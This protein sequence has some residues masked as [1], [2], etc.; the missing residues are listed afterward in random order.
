MQ[1]FIKFFFFLS[2]S[3]QD[4]C[5]FREERERENFVPEKTSDISHFDS[6]FFFLISVFQYIYTIVVYFIF[7]PFLLSCTSICWICS[8]LLTYLY[9]MWRGQSGAK[10]THF[11][12]MMKYERNTAQSTGN[13]AENNICL[14]LFSYSHSIFYI[15]SFLTVASIFSS[16]N[17]FTSSVNSHPYLPTSNLNGPIFLDKFS[18]QILE[19]G[20]SVSL[21]LRCTASGHPLPQ[22]NWLLDGKSIPDHSRFR[23]GDYVTRDS[24][25][26]VSINCTC[27]IIVWLVT[28]ILWERKKNISSLSLS[29]IL[30]WYFFFTQSYVNITS[31]TPQDGGLYV[32]FISTSGWSL[33]NQKFYIPFSFDLEFSLSLTH[34][35]LQW[36]ELIFL[37]L[38]Q[39]C[40]ASN[41]IAQIKHSGNLKIFG[42]PHI[43]SME[44]ASA[45]AG[46]SFTV[47]CP[48][49]GHPIEKIFWEKGK[50]FLTLCYTFFPC[51]TPSI[52]LP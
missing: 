40:T 44:N 43:R 42:P 6:L 3:L 52:F 13:R 17:S 12:E 18:E 16:V 35:L 51:W 8:F 34:R 23:T 48:V 11:E 14:F 28:G 15:I 39:E 31:V 32:S 37:L 29:L 46:E 38:Q 10:V 21:S 26:V 30:W 7:P 5:S 22:V 27:L 20:P 2:S 45:V 25:V 47:H 33:F 19:P 50:P 4:K 49:T 9:C 1:S 36:I 41:D 24:V